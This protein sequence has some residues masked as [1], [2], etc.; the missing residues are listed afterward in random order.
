M[1]VLRTID[2]YSHLDLGVTSKVDHLDQFYVILLHIY[3]PYKNFTLFC[4]WFTCWSYSFVR[5][6][7]LT[8]SFIDDNLRCTARKPV[9][10]FL[11]SRLVERPLRHMVFG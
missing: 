5:T 3:S 1:V 11:P 8:T 9:I 10:P 7:V 4:L 2:S 6:L